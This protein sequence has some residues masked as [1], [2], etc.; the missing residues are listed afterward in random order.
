[1]R[2]AAWCAGVG[3]DEAFRRVFDHVLRR[4]AT[5]ERGGPGVVGVGVIGVGERGGR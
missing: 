1:M 4:R 3:G 2:R 5:S